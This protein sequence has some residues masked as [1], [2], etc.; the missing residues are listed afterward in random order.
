M[1][2]ITNSNGIYPKETRVILG[3][4]Y[5]RHSALTLVDDH[6]ESGEEIEDKVESCQVQQQLEGDRRQLDV[7]LRWHHLLHCQVTKTN[8]RLIVHGKALICQ[9]QLSHMLTLAQVS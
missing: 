7:E 3:L 8:N 4:A 5:A 1:T 6:A 2:N 9:Q